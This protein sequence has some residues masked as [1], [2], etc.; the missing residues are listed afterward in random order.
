MRLLVCG[1][2]INLDAN[3]CKQFKEK[4]LY[5]VTEKECIL[6]AEAYFGVSIEEIFKLY[7]IDSI[8]KAIEKAMQKEI[9]I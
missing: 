4:I 9:D 3:I 6:Y 7:P 8:E 1:N 2:E 5:D